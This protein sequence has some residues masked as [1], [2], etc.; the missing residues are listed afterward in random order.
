MYIDA[1][2]GLIVEQTIFADGGNKKDGSNR[3][4]SEQTYGSREEEAYVELYEDNEEFFSD[5]S[6]L[7][8]ALLSAYPG[9]SKHLDDR[10]DGVNSDIFYYTEWDD[11]IYDEFKD[12]EDISD[13]NSHV[14]KSDAEVKAFEPAKEPL[15]E[16]PRSSQNNNKRRKDEILL[17]HRFYPSRPERRRP[18]LVVTSFLR[19]IA[20]NHCSVSGPF[21]R[22]SHKMSGRHLPTA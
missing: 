17:D 3:Q 18:P 1:C 12:Y 14:L 9:V 22:G 5:T 21:R 10:N 2:N 6:D 4:Q 13:D 11:P 15:V 8:Q 20:L 19:L 16:T 7:E